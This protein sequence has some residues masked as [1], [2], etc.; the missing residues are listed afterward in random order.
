MCIR[1]SD[2]DP[3]KTEPG[4]CGCNVEEGTC[5]PSSENCSA[6]VYSISTIYSQAGNVVT[7]QG[8]AYQNKW[9]SR[10]DIPT[11]GDPW[12]LIVVCDDSGEDCTQIANWNAGTV[13]SNRGTQVTY[14]GKIYQNKW[15]SRDDLP[16]EARVW[17]FI[18][19]CST[20]LAA[21]KSGSSQ[22]ISTMNTTLIY[23]TL[24]NENITV[25]SPS[26]LS[27]SLIHISEPTRPY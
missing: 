24:F 2:N 25:T 17:E 1:D 15:Y 19:V 11:A 27:L 22:N 20:S 4:E 8:R 23:P 7:Y 5:D 10:G 21:V 9:Y 6:P 13:Y 26:F 3:N 16:G 18:N 14:E 12:E